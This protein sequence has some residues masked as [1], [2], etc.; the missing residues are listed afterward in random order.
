[1][2]SRQGCSTASANFDTRSSQSKNF[3]SC[4]N[5]CITEPTEHN[6]VAEP[7]TLPVTTTLEQ[8]PMTQLARAPQP[9]ATRSTLIND[10]PLDD[11]AGL[12]TPPTSGTVPTQTR[13]PVTALL[14]E[15]EHLLE[16]DDFGDEGIDYDKKDM[17][18]PFRAEPAGQT[19]DP[20]DKITI[21]GTALQQQRIRKLCEK[22]IY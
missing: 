12:I 3:G 7:I 15:T 14:R 6:S 16:T 13:R 19:A 10:T 11:R 9:S 17:F 20:L 18:A 8:R 1:M 2:R 21:S 4:K 22:Y 5:N